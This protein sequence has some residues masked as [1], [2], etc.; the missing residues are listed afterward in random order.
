MWEFKA[1]RFQQIQAK[2]TAAQNNSNWNFDQQ[3]LLQSVTGGQLVFVE[4]IEIYADNAVS[5][6]AIT[7]T[8][9]VANAAD[10]KNSTLTLS[11]LGNLRV[12]NLPLSRINPIWSDTAAYVPF[13]LTPVLWCNMWGIDWTQSFVTTVAAAHTAPLSFVFGIWYMYSTDPEADQYIQKM[14]G[15]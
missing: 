3:P 13:T 11:V 9:A 8:N 5:A 10:I 7:P 14:P 2:V 6:S 1:R 15:S 12:N 4:A